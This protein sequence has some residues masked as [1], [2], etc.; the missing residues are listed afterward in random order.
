MNE[1]IVFYTGGGIGG[2]FTGIPARN[3]S[4]T[5]VQNA[6]GLEY[7]LG[8]GLYVLADEPEEVEEAEPEEDEI[9]K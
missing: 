9:T 1:I 7:V 4:E 3:L 8:T 2:S 6:G 5:E